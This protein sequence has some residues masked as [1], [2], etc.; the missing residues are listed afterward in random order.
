MPTPSAR[1]RLRAS[2]PA[3]AAA[4]VLALV[5]GL[6]LT[7]CASKPAASA[8]EPSPTPIARLN[9]ASMQLPRIDFCRLVPSTAVRDALGAKPATSAAYGNGDTD[10]ASGAGGQVLH[11]IGCTWSAADGTSARA[12]VFARPADAAL[13]QAVLETAGRPRGCR[14]VPGPS[15][16][17]PTLTQQCM[18]PGAAGSTSQVPRLRHAGLFGQTWLTCEVAG[19]PGAAVTEVGVRADAWCVEVAESL[20]TSR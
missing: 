10:P 4:A 19:A 9:T 20:N 7:G 2:A 6:V 12:W 3:G 17:S 11:E 14:A 16:G 8:P 1:R 18:L 13:A 5:L 15:F